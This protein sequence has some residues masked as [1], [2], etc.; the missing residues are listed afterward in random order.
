MTVLSR[1]LRR[2]GEWI[3]TPS[4]KWWAALSIPWPG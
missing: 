4:L 2:L 1:L 3:P